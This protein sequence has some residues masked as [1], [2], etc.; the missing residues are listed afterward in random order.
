MQTTTDEPPFEVEADALGERL[1]AVRLLR[2]AEA[3]V[4]ASLRRYG[5]LSPLL[6][7]RSGAGSLEVLDGFRRLRAAQQYGWPRRL[8]VQVLAVD[9]RGALAALV[10]L[11]RG[12]A[13]L[14]E[15]EQ[16]L[17][18]RAL[19]REQSMTQAAA[20]QLLGRDQSWVSRRLLLIES[21]CEDVQ[22]DVRLG[23][24]PITAARDIAR[25]PRGIQAAA[26]CA[27][28][29]G[30]LSVRQASQLCASLVQAG[31]KDE[32]DVERLLGESRPVPLEPSDVATYRAQ[33]G[34]LSRCVMRV[35]RRLCTHP[36][37]SLSPAQTQ[38]V[39]TLI[40]AVRGPLGLLC[41]LM[42]S[43]LEEHQ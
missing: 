12:T 17:V 8:R 23:L 1:G 38:L 40:S 29:S 27:I 6:C 16:A 37:S 31:A 20:A 3:E 30:N 39:R 33:L 24:L 36:P 34:V 42:D 14:S 15:L 10:S 13:G 41:T 43:H 26:A 2:P 5:Q 32:D 21:L 18:V 35:G 28:A 9:E 19:V 4:A 7:Y 25:M 22:Q 11:H